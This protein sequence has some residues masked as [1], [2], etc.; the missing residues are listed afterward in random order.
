MSVWKKWNC[1]QVDTLEIA[2]REQ[3]DQV[4]RFFIGRLLSHA[5]IS[6]LLFV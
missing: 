5:L 6:R 2:L 4:E 3:L 1:L